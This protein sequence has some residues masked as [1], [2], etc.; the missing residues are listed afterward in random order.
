MSPN[1][2]SPVDGIRW[3]DKTAIVDVAGEIDLNTS[4]AFQQELLAVLDKSPR[5]IVV[6]LSGVSY[7]DSSGVA[8]LVKLLSR[9]RRSSAG[10][11]LFGL[12]DRVRGVFEITR[13]DSVFEIFPTEEEALA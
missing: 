2:G 12:T 11:R 3:N 13:L 1:A 4:N 9:V 7:M 10:L 8:S 5:R 6:N